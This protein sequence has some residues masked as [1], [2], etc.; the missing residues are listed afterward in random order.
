MNR[1]TQRTQ[2]LND[3][4]VDAIEGGMTGQWGEIYALK[5]DDDLN[6]ISC[7]VTDSIDPI[8]DKPQT[9]T[10]TIETIAKGFS[11][12]RESRKSETGYLFHAS[13][14]NGALAEA[15]TTNGEDGDYDAIDA[16]A[17]LQLG[18]FGEVIYG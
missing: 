11:L 7:K 4:L 12:W 1:S 9:W 15:D 17:L 18:L 10:V 6:I 3:V 16:D 5:R 2:F 8:E 14:G 13:A